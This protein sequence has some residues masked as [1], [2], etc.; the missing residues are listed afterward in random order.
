MAWVNS[1]ASTCGIHAAN[2]S[3][4]SDLAD[5][6]ALSNLAAHFLDCGELHKDQ[7]AVRLNVTANTQDHVLLG[8]VMME[9]IQGAQKE[10]A[11][12]AIMTLEPDYQAVIAQLLQTQMAGLFELQVESKAAKRASVSYNELRRLSGGNLH[13]SLGDDGMREEL[14]R[15]HSELEEYTRK[16]DLARQGQKK[17]GGSLREL[18]AK[19]CDEE[20]MAHEAEK[21]LL[22]FEDECR[23]SVGQLD[24]LRF[25]VAQER[26]NEVEDDSIV[27]IRRRIEDQSRECRDWRAK[28]DDIRAHIDH[29]HSSG[30][31]QEKEN[32]RRT[33]LLS[34]IVRLEEAYKEKENKV[35]A[36]KGQQF[37]EEK[38][39]ANIEYQMQSAAAELAVSD[40]RCSEMSS[41]AIGAEM[42]LEYAE[43]KLH[44]CTSELQVFRKGDIDGLNEDLAMRGVIAATLEQACGDAHS[45]YLVQEAEVP[46][47]EEAIKR[48][49]DDLAELHQKREAG[50]NDAQSEVQ[51]D[52]DQAKKVRMELTDMR[53]NV[54]REEDQVRRLRVEADQATASRVSAHEEANAAVARYNAEASERIKAQFPGRG[55]PLPKANPVAAAAQNGTPAAAVGAVGSQA[56]PAA[57]A[58][59]SQPVR[60]KSVG[61]QLAMGKTM[62]SKAG[63]AAARLSQAA[64][65]AADLMPTAS[66]PMVAK[67]REQL[68]L[69]ER[70]LVWRESMAG[71][72]ETFHQ[73]EVKLISGA[74]HQLGLKYAKVLSECEA[75]MSAE[76]DLQD[77]V[78][79]EALETLRK[80]GGTGPGGEAKAKSAMKPA[81]RGA[82]K[83]G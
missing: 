6:V 68:V 9:A 56:T 36:V 52:K 78:E 14:K 53:A 69:R 8:M 23:K 58:A 74:I 66:A 3:S 60:R 30:E 21:N 82:L 24:H 80:Q 40:E 76:Q 70:E 17:A 26:D 65:N 22:A 42:E 48:V 27:K 10:Q 32:W 13:P 12:G 75:A 47:L 57:A 1:C 35:R 62:S 73:R 64:G 44:G 16:A 72:A 63:R 77:E 19:L 55:A 43:S 29:A 83:A 51:A 46:L 33:A 5:G 15:L 71:E 50:A 11:I 61:G 79:E 59:S 49:A 38:A 4:F 20:D 31:K 25:E 81:L 2:I 67:L 34:K 28:Q 54:S 41:L 18:R 37:Q 39:T 7:L 45:R